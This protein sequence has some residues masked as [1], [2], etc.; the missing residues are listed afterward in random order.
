MRTTITKFD[1]T[2]GVN[3]IDGEYVFLLNWYNIIM[4]TINIWRFN[5]M[6]TPD[7]QELFELRIKNY[8]YVHRDSYVATR[9]K[10]IPFP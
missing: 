3:T 9:V 6:V 4:R 8:L 10:T 7:F 5:S 1:I 2:E